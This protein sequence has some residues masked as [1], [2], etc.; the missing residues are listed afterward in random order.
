MIGLGI[1]SIEVV[2][3]VCGIQ[4]CCHYPRS[5]LEKGK[6]GGCCGVEI[7]KARGCS[8]SAIG[9]IVDGLFT[10]SESLLVTHPGAFLLVLALM[11][12]VMAPLE[13]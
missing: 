10:D 8:Q 3:Y 2:A 5:Q 12:M 9:S 6:N 11:V 13:N 7:L 1:R 4:R